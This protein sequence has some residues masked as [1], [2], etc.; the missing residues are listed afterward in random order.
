M[1]RYDHNEI[2][3]PS[4]VE[5]CWIFFIVLACCFA[6]AYGVFQFAQFLGWIPD[7]WWLP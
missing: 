4:W 7:L 5:E 1:E 2:S 3:Y 6:V